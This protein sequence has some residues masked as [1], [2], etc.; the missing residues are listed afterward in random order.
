MNPSEGPVPFAHHAI[1]KVRAELKTQRAGPGTS[2][3][4]D[5]SDNRKPGH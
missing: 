3:P 2:S 5:V 4:A 1:E